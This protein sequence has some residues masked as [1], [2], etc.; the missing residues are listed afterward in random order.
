ME[1]SIPFVPTDILL[2]K[3][4][5][6]TKWSV[7]AC[8]QY[9]SEPK[10]WNSVKKFVGSA[11]S[12]LKITLPEIYLENENVDGMTEDINRTMKEYLSDSLFY[13]VKNSFIYVRR[14]LADGKIRKGIVGAVDLEQYDFSPDSTS[15]IRA[16]EGTVLKRLPPRVRIRKDATLELPHIMLLIDDPDM[17][18]IEPLEEKKEQFEKLYDFE[19]MQNSGS[20]KGYRISEECSKQITDAL[21]KIAANFEKAHNGNLLLFAVGD[22][23]HSLATAKTCFENLKLTTPKEYFM[24]HPSRYALVEVVNLHDSS[25]QFEPIHRAVFGVDGQKFVSG[26]E[27]LFAGKTDG[28]QIELNSANFR[29]TIFTGIDSAGLVVDA[30]Q[31]YIDRYLNEFGGKEDYIHGDE[32]A[33]SLGVQPQNASILLP[34]LE[35]SE[36]FPSIAEKGTF[37][38]KTFSMGHACDKRFYLECR[39][40][41]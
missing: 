33:R 41:L 24:N 19:L 3:N 31:K 1:N 32:V 38:R 25:L 40:I 20:L 23:N 26:L 28:K 39:K 17:T 36:F 8:D 10:Y 18:V 35:K 2:P 34:K 12:T 29:K 30:V 4:C 13:E 5:D 15:K 37:P 27:D 11:P 9:T 6:M 7:V 16:T 14:M 21:A 22:G